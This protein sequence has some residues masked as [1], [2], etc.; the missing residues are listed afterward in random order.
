LE[1]D[2][3]LFVINLANHDHFFIIQYDVMFG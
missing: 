3:S 2:I 1:C